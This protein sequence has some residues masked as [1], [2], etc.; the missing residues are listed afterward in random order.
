MF[1]NKFSHCGGSH[2]ARR[3]RRGMIGAW[4]FAAVA[5]C[6]GG[7]KHAWAQGR[8]GGDADQGK[9]D[10]PG[11]LWMRAKVQAHVADALDVAK[12]TPDQRKAVQAEV[13]ALLQ[14]GKSAHVA[15]QQARD[16]ALQLFR[17]DTLAT[18]AIDALR[19]ELKDSG[20]GHAKEVAAAAVR[21]HGLFQPDQRKAI[22]A[23]VTE[24]LPATKGHWQDKMM[25][26]GVEHGTDR[27]LDQLQV[28][29]DQ[30]KALVAIRDRAIDQMAARKGQHRQVMAQ[31]LAL[32]QA[33]K[34]DPAQVRAQLD[35]H[36]T[37]RDAM[38]QWASPLAQ[39]VHHVLTPAQRGKLSEFLQK[40]GGRFS[41]GRPE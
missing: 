35:S 38:L 13:D 30:R 28:T 7:A 4:V 12:A 26:F 19:Q 9:A 8:G 6:G 24:L 2:G 20:D 36:A 27:A 34:V 18:K 40:I 15:R 17:A 5:V 3:G 10:H 14:R 39:E 16:K 41:H 1:G 29:P 25:R 32:W 31:A 21:I 23:Y 37:H 22:G 33:D 11:A